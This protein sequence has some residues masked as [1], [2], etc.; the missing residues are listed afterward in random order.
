MTQSTLHVMVGLL[1]TV[2]LAVTAQGGGRRG[3]W[4]ETAATPTPAKSAEEE[5]DKKKEEEE[6]EKGGDG[7]SE[8]TEKGEGSEEPKEAALH[9]LSQEEALA[10]GILQKQAELAATQYCDMLQGFVKGAEEMAD[11][12]AAPAGSQE[13]DADLREQALAA[14][15]DIMQQAGITP[16]ELMMALSGAGG[17]EADAAAAEEAA[18]AEAAAAAAGASSEGEKMGS[19]AKPS[20]D[21]MLAAVKAIKTLAGVSS[22]DGK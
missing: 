18:A 13:A 9:E 8:K 4:M 7:E 5:G 10:V 11:P 3:I 19:V 1:V 16:E 2:M 20:N 21:E 12:S 22:A 15:A 17:S 14:I 6:E